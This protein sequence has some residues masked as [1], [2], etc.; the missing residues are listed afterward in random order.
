[1]PWL[2]WNDIA[3]WQPLLD[4]LDVAG[5]NADPFALI[6]S[7]YDGLVVFHG[8]R[9]LDISA[10]HVSGVRPVCLDELHARVRDLVANAEP[11]VPVQALED[12]IRCTPKPAVPAQVYACVD[13]RD[14]VQHGQHFLGGS[15]HVQ[16]IL[17]ILGE[18]LGCDF[19][20][21]LAATGTPAIL[22]L[23]V[24]W[25]DLGEY[26]SDQIQASLSDA[27]ESVAQGN[28]PARKDWCH[29]QLTAIPSEQILSIRWL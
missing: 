24:P 10:Y 23:A 13:E 9:P 4:A 27:I 16:H 14:L 17:Q 20:D 19:S 25:R 3:S 7:V 29:A 5:P 22:E 6:R 28:A 26:V 1:M 2:K 18:D 12:A 8:C 11:K 21:L 15:E